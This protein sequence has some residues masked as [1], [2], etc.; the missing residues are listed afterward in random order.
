MAVEN[1]ELMIMDANQVP[2]IS[3]KLAQNQLQKTEEHDI[4][5]NL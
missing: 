3:S 2:V 5:F 1:G 4:L